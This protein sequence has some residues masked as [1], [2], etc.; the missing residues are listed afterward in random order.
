MGGVTEISKPF[1]LRESSD[2]I[3]DIVDEGVHDTHGLRIHGDKIQPGSKRKS[4]AK[5]H[6]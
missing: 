6:L 1:P 5:R 4:K 3:E 2:L